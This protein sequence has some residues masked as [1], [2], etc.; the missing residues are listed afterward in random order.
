MVTLKSVSIFSI[1]SVSMKQETFVV[2]W[3][4]SVNTLK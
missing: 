2:F 1:M 4:K 3:T